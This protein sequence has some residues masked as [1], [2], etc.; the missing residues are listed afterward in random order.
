MAPLN[1]SIRLRVVRG[2]PYSNYTV[3]RIQPFNCRY[4]RLSVI[5]NYPSRTTPSTDD[6][7]KQ[8]FANGLCISSPQSPCFKIPCERT[9]CVYYISTSIGYFAHVHYVRMYPL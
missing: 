8:E 9:S 7:F 5:R 1:G 3:L 4:K 6:L 2:N